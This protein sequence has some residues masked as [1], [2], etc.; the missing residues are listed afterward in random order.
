MRKGIILLLV[1]ALILGCTAKHGNVSVELKILK[2]YSPMKVERGIAP[3]IGEINAKTIRLE[4]KEVR[5]KPSETVIVKG[6]LI[7]K[8]YYINGKR[9][10]YCGNV[11][12]EVYEAKYTVGSWSRVSEGLGRRLCSTKTFL[13]PNSTVPFELEI[14][15]QR[16]VT[17]LIVA[18]GEWW[19][20]WTFLN[21]TVG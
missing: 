16:K 14:T 6:W 12:L 1:V 21:V 10:Y 18:K 2:S 4:S 19:K 7:S 9:Y 3:S 8:P 17:L 11:T 20:S 5:T 13:P 15:G